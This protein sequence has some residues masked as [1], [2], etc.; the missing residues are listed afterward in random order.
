[1]KSTLD[2]I[3]DGQSGVW[4]EYRYAERNGAVKGGK[5]AR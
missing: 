4:S 1:M 2:Y 5:N 3:P